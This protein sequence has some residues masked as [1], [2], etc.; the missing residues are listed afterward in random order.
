[1][2]TN[3]IG[4]KAVDSTLV[5]GNTTVT[6]AADDTVL[7]SDTSDSGNLK[8]ATIGTITDTADGTFIT[9][10]GN[11]AVASDDTVLI[12]D[13]SDSGNLKKALISTI[14][15]TADG[16]F[17]TGN[18]SVTAAAGD[19]VLISDLSDS[20]NLK[21]A[22]ISTLGNTVDKTFITANTTVTAA[23]DD[24]ILISDTSDTGNLKK[25]LIST[26]TDTMVAN[27]GDNRILTDTSTA[28]SINGEANLT[29][30]GTT[31]ALTG[32][33]TASGTINAT[34]V[35]TA[36][37]FTI[38]SAVIGETELEILDGATLSTTELNKLDGAT[39]STAELNSL[40]S[41]GSDTVATQLATK[42]PL[43]SPALTGT[44]TA[45]NLTVSGNL[46]ING[47]TTTVSSTNTTITDNLL[48]LN[49]G[50]SSNANDSGILIERGSTGDNAFMGFDESSDTF[51]LGTTTAT[52]D[53]T[54]NLSITPSKITV[55]GVVIGSADVNEAELEILDGATVSTTELNVLDGIPGTLTATEL[56]YVDGVTSAIQTQLDSKQA[57]ITGS[58]T[59]ID[60]ESLTASRAVISNASQK[61]AVSATT[62]TE[63]GY[64][65]G[66]TSAIQTQIDSKFATAGGAL[67]GDLQLAAND[68]LVNDG[69]Y[70]YFGNSNDLK[71]GHDG[72]NSVIQDTGAGD[73]YID[74]DNIHYFRTAG[75]GIKAKFIKDGAVELYYSGSKKLDTVTGGVSITGDVTASGSFVIGSASMNETDLEKLD[76]ITNGTAAANKAVVLDGNKAIST[77]TTATI[78]NLST[79]T[80]SGGAITSSNFAGVTTLL[81]KNSAGST[82]K[83]IRSPSS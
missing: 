6:A 66:V 23:S 36:G 46:T 47:S 55:G 67:T 69:G 79:T 64:V 33:Q 82:L 73:L 21:K 49:S 43:A 24:S 25:A 50:A 14:I 11:V 16:T 59:T 61:I 52:A 30:D 28:G 7:I 40:A 26:I 81:I 31:L 10:K 9:D 17:I 44:A 29:F 54:G 78:T 13:T 8:K 74:S 3:T 56:G 83:T 42:A 20:G 35:V 5:T 76:D 71:I 62:A 27:G 38:G 18:S 1:M 68:I 70:A 15:D 32:N 34:G 41:I 37:G 12:S 57:T 4:N 53:A 19:T 77:I 22:L 39:V 60:S 80:L 45:V 58:A 48:E 51:V 63:L 75:G 2:A 65:N 72:S